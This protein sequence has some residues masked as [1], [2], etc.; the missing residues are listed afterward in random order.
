MN[1]SNQNYVRSIVLKD[2]L[3]LEQI[4]RGVN[5]DITQLDS[6]PFECKIVQL[7]AGNVLASLISSNRRLRVRGDVSFLT[8]SLL[9][10][11]A[12]SAKWRGNR[13]NAHDALAAKPG[14]AFDLVM[15]PNFELICISTVGNAEFV[16]RNLGGPVFAEK[17][18]N[19]GDPIS[20]APNS[21]RQ[22]KSWLSDC[23]AD[24][25]DEMIIPYKQ[26]RE[27]ERE[28]IRRLA[29]CLR[30]GTPSGN[31]KRLAPG[32]VAVVQR[33][34]EH[35][36]GDIAIPQS[37]ND[38]CAVAGTSRRTLEYAFKDYFGTSPKKFVKALR[39][40][41]A[42]GDLLRGDRDSE[43]VVEIASGWGFSHM[44]QFSIDYRHMFG[45]TPGATLRRSHATVRV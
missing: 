38:L 22:M 17:L 45:E 27:L 44:G 36:L 10:S 5:M 13:V 26:S 25:K 12:G 1:S 39:L 32:R 16:L 31:G 41:A 28:F 21:M 37:I 15:P 35:L 40:N 9:A 3:D 14:E 43:L 29:S 4:A 24:F 18:A 23:F 8:I 33:V 7:K 42:H 20:C 34:E 6:G 2:A 11:N 30:A 19:T